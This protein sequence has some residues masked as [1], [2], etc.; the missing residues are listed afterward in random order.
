MR[1]ENSGAT[2]ALNLVPRDGVFTR[3]TLPAYDDE[4]MGE[5]TSRSVLGPGVAMTLFP[6]SNAVVSSEKQIQ[7]VV[8]GANRIFVRGE[9]AYEDIFGEKHSTRF[10]F[11]TTGENYD[12][13]P[14]SACAEQ[15]QVN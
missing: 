7:A 15:N 9:V 14:L 3:P 5:P 12:K 8:I 13:A 6:V 2:P 1:I 11:S 10:C 4:I